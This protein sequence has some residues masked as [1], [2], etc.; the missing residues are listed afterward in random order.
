ME[1]GRIQ[2]LLN[3]WVPPYYLRN[4]KA[5]NFKFCMHFTG[6]IGISEQ[7]SIKN[8]GKS[9]SVRSLGPP[10]IFKAAIYIAHRAVIFAIAQLSRLL[11]ACCWHL[12]VL[13]V[14][15]I[16]LWTRDRKVA[17]STPGRGAIK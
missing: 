3:F 9:S 15:L 16:E 13:V 4:N 10:K 12:V 5:T 17:G 14:T 8:V 6:S 1:R 11:L 7:K 2:K